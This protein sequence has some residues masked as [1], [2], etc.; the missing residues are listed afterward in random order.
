MVSSLNDPCSFARCRFLFHLAY[1]FPV[2]T[3]FLYFSII[4][5][6]LFAVIDSLRVDWVLFPVISTVL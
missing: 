4:I 5:L 3:G 1:F 6:Y 2:L